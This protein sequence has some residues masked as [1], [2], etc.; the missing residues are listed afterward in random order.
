[1]PKIFSPSRALLLAALQ[2]STLTVSA[3][4]VISEFMASNRESLADSDSDY[5]DW[6]ELSN[7]TPSPLALGGHFLTDDPDRPDRWPIPELTLAPGEHRV[8]FASGKDRSNPAS[9]LHTNF[10]LNASG[11]SISITAPDAST[12]IH[13]VTYP[14]QLADVSY[15]TGT[16]GGS[17]IVLDLTPTDFSTSANTASQIRVSAGGG[18][19]TSASW[20]TLDTLSS[21]ALHQRYLWFDYSAALDSVPEGFRVL[22]ST[23][24][25]TPDT[26]PTTFGSYNSSLGIFPCPDSNKGID[27]ILT[28]SVGSEITDYFAANTPIATTPI[29]TATGSAPVSWDTSDLVSN[30]LANPT[31]QR[32]GQ[33]LVLSRDEPIFVRWPSAGPTMTAILTNGTSDEPSQLYFSTPTPGTTNGAGVLGFVADT[34]FSVDRGFHDT[35]FE[36][37]ITS[38]TPGASIVYTT[39]GSDPT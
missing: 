4:P 1:M 20:D 27:T 31:G 12:T 11:G 5:P 37:A 7:P 26:T 34:K 6:I 10:Q 23:T 14:K 38:A 28:N 21:G 33:F 3:T 19:T 13:S 9:E 16:S 36:L 35:A 39:D 17:T 30:W 18:G 15:G 32:R 22:S 25:W 29:S 2:L 24:T 8:I